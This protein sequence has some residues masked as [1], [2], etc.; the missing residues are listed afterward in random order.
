MIHIPV[1]RNVVSI[2]SLYKVIGHKFSVKHFVVLLTTV[3]TGKKNVFLRKT[4]RKFSN[5]KI[6]T[7]KSFTVE[8]IFSSCNVHMTTKMLNTILWWTIDL[9]FS[10]HYFHSNFGRECLIIHS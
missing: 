8:R 6:D 3:K 4:V 7:Q 2:L 9:N 1:I 10:V 5:N